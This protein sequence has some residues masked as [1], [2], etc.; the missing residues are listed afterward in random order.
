MGV[1]YNVYSSLFG[2]DKGLLRQDKEFPSIYVVDEVDENHC[3]LLGKDKR[4]FVKNIQQRLCLPDQSNLYLHPE[5]E[6]K[7]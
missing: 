3:P 1:Y 2:K 4:I 7:E 5:R 6:I